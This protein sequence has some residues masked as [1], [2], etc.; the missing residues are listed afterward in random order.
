MNVMDYFMKINEDMASVNFAYSPE[1]LE[2]TIVSRSPDK[3]ESVT[4][5]ISRD[6]MVE[7]KTVLEMILQNMG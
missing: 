3:S 7:M 6:E 4:V 2:M 1:H 5:D